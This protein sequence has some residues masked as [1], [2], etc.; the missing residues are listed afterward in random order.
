MSQPGRALA[1]GLSYPR[2]SAVP[3]GPYPGLGPD[4]VVFILDTQTFDGSTMNV[5]SFAYLR[6]PG[7]LPSFSDAYPY[8][9]QAIF[10]D[11]TG[12]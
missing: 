3:G 4:S 9:P 8:A 11:V 10:A 5:S 7:A 2:R 6:T 1:A 12:Y